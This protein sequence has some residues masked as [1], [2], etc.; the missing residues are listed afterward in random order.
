VGFFN[1]ADSVRYPV[2][3]YFLGDAFTNADQIKAVRFLWVAQVSHPDSMQAWKTLAD[4]LSGKTPGKWVIATGTREAVQ[5]LATNLCLPEYRDSLGGKP[6][7]YPP[8]ALVDKQGFVRGGNNFTSK[9]N[10]TPSGYYFSTKDFDMQ[11]LKEDMRALMMIEYPQ[12][13]K[14]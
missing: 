2:A 10:E 12:D 4:S 5:Q 6:I 7:L 1:R 11:K 3:K 13:M 8:V 9:K 14:K